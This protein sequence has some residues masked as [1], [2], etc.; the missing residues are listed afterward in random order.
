MNGV[1]ITEKGVVSSLSSTD[2]ILIVK[3]VTENGTTKNDVRRVTVGD[4]LSGLNVGGVASVE[5]GTNEDGESGLVVTYSDGRADFIQVASGSGGLGIAD[6]GTTY[7]AETNVYYAHLY[8]ESGND[9]L[10]P[11]PLPATGGSGGGT[12]ATMRPITSRME[13]KRFTI[14][15]DAETCDILYSW[16]SVEDGT[17]DPTGPG[18]AVWYVNNTLRYSQ[19]VPQGNN[20]FDIRRELT[21]G[22]ENTVKLTITDEYGNSRSCTWVITVASYSLSWNADE[23]SNHGNS[24]YALR[25]T[26][27]G[28]GSK[29][30]VVSV[31]DREIYRKTITTSGITESVTVP[32]QSHGSHT[33]LAWLEVE[34]DGRTVTTE[35]LRHVGIWARTGSTAPIVSVFEDEIT[36]NRYGTYAIRYSVYDPGA[37]TADV[38]LKEGTATV[39]TLHVDRTVQTWMYRATEAGTETLSISCTG[40]SGETDTATI[41]VNVQG[42][43]VDVNPITDSLIIDL[44]PSGHSNADADRA[45]FGYT[46]LQGANHPLILS[47]NFDWNSGGFQTDADGNVAFV[48]RRGCTAQLDASLFTN[49]AKEYGK[50]I[51]II[52]KSTNCRDYDTEIMRSFANNVGLLMTA[53]GVTYR[54]NTNAVRTDYLEGVR[55]EL[56]FDTESWEDSGGLRRMRIWSEGTPGKGAIYAR[57]SLWMQSNPELFTIGSNDADVWIYHLRVYSRHLTNAEILANFV[58]DAP[59]PEEI[60]ARSKRNQIYTDDMSA[61]SIPALVNAAPNLHVFNISAARFPDDKD[62]QVP[63]TIEHWKGAVAS[64]YFR[65]IGAGFVLQG[66]SSLHYI[67]SAGN[68]D[69]DMREATVTDGDGQTVTGYCMEPTSMPELYFC[70]KVNVAS[71]ENAN[72]VCAA[73]LFNTYN[74]LVSLAKSRDPRVRDSIEG[75]PCAIF[76]TNTGTTA[77]T[78]GSNLARV[79]QPGE[80]IFYAAGDMCNSKK[81]FDVFGQTD[82]LGTD[83]DGIPPFCVEF[84]DNGYERCRFLDSDFS[85]ETWD[86]SAAD[87]KGQFEFRY[88][89]K[90]NATQAMKNKFISMQN[91]VA[92]TNTQNATGRLL[93]EL[94]VT[95]TGGVTL[96]NPLTGLNETFL[97]DTATYRGCKF[98]AEM[99]DWY[100]VDGLIFYYV[101]TLFFL[102]VDQRCKNT[103]CSYE[104]DKDGVWRFNFSRFY[105]GDTILGINNKGELSLR[106]GIEDDDRDSNNSPYFNGS[107]S[108]LWCNIREYCADLVTSMYSRM[109]TAGLFR[110]STLIEKFDSY[111]RVRPEALM[112]EDSMAK[113]DGP[114]ERNGTQNYFE[115]MSN[116]EKRPQRRMF[117]TYQEIYMSSK[118]R[119]GAARN[120]AILLNCYVPDQS[121]VAAGSYVRLKPYC[122]MYL[123]AQ[124]DN[125]GTVYIRATKGE[126][127]TL[128][129]T[130]RNGNYVS[131]KDTAVRLFRGDYISDIDSLAQ[132]YTQQCNVSIAKKLRRLPLGSGEAG[133]SNSNLTTL[134]ITGATMLEYIDVRGLIS[135]ETSLDVS[136]CVYL[137]EL[138]ASGSA[139]TGVTF[140]DGAGV[141]TAV[142]PAVYNLIAVNLAALQT[143]SMGMGNISLIRVEDSPGIDTEEIVSAANTLNFVRML[144]VNWEFEYADA[145]LRLVGKM[146]LDTSNEPSGYPAI[147]SGAVRV[148]HISESELATLQNE[149]PNVTFTHGEPFLGEYTVTFKDYDGTVLNT[150]QVREG[151]DAVNP[152]PGIIGT[153]TRP[154]TATVVYTFAGWDRTFTNV[155]QNLIVTA[156]YMETAP[157][158]TVNFWYDSTKSELL[159]S[160]TVAAGGSAVYSGLRPTSENGIFSGWSGSSENV[161]RNLDLYAVFSAPTQPSVV[162]AEGTYAYLYSDFPEDNKA[163]SYSEFMW[164][165]LK[166]PNPWMYVRYG[167]KARFKIEAE[168]LSDTEITYVAGGKEH[169]KMSDGSGEF[170][171]IVWIPEHLLNSTYP[172]NSTAT[173]TGGWGLPSALWQ[174]LQNRVRPALPYH[175]RYIMAQVKVK[176]CSVIDSSRATEYKEIDSYLF[177]PS[178]Y[179]IGFNDFPDEVDGGVAAENRVFSIFTDPNSRVRTVLGSST[180]TPWWVR[181]PYTT[182]TTNFCVVTA[183]GTSNNSNATASGIGVLC[184]F[185]TKSD[186]QG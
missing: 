140:A 168:D 13:S 184:G 142:L 108:V 58:A 139:L 120:N 25:I 79:V 1:R 20:S 2:Y 98:R 121:S 127:K 55:T 166:A 174:Y 126:W 110:A 143:F 80:T 88:P 22:T 161:T 42:I 137:E 114:L 144:D 159:D 62:N 45:Q 21:T 125:Y 89:K 160:Q 104:P 96:Y 84:M 81:T 15:D 68:L 128:Q 183:T 103:F 149:F 123:A 135:L 10:D 38:S 35:P 182:G 122:D 28:T 50:H 151:N 116:G 133:Y 52:F 77:I 186:H 138:Y 164:I 132:L 134:G 131:L 118:F 44:D 157:T 111:Q 129:V 97:R 33:V 40:S 66:T 70:L 53:Q 74:P 173:N 177:T 172:M 100:D 147:L 59:T 63:C 93:S 18:D 101:F 72:N 57:E 82:T 36:M 119:S 3:P 154:G 51:E 113:Y 86:N 7:N 83:E 65:A 17:D 6:W 170:A 130:D 32:A 5:P 163:Y 136:N 34:V 165:V 87:G 37:D 56:C 146:G 85:E 27:S 124:F 19:S 75:H 54:C 26:P 11:M 109:E 4:F 117:L 73:D 167:D 76:F 61:I 49:N 153:P 48:V 99:P 169:F 39:G 60:V 64:H 12:G 105:D 95:E 150:Q 47:S 102:G 178:R 9:L 69:V 107:D 179:E 175:L 46:D 30:L 158:Y 106:Y 23:I 24:A 171:D 91:W 41:T 155:H 176:Y 185:C 152:V 90:K 145:M 181:T 148:E 115:N 71:S 162:A 94:G 156:Q 43:G 8:D 31:D 180:G 112:V 29:D 141:V 67:E 78:L 14:M 92:S 16:S